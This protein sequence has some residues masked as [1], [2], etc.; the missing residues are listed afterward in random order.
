VS[1]LLLEGAR[2][3]AY[4]GLVIIAAAPVEA[5]LEEALAPETRTLLIGKIVRDSA[6]HGPEAPCE[7]QDIHH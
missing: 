4:D 3:R 2:E 5:E 7:Q 6:W 1:Q